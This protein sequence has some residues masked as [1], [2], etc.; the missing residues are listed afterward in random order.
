MLVGRSEELDRIGS[1]LERARA[2][3]A[4]ALVLRGEP[5]IGK[6]ALLDHARTSAMGCCVLRAV[7]VQSE[8]ELACAGLHQLLRPLLPRVDDLPPPQAAALRATFAVDASVATERFTVYLAT[9]G[10]IAAAAESAPVLCV[11]DDA[12]WL[13]TMSA[14]ALAFVARRLDAEPVAMLFAT[15]TGER[16]FVADGLAVLELGPLAANASEALLASTSPELNHETAATLL[17]AAAGNPLALVEL[18][19]ALTDDEIGGTATV[20]EPVR[21]T[22]A[23]EAAFLARIQQLSPHARRALLVVSALAASDALPI[24]TDQDLAS[25]LGEAEAAGLVRSVGGGV[26]FRHPLMRAAAY[27]AATTAER[28]SAHALLASWLDPTVDADEYAWQL[29]EATPQPD[30]SVAHLLVETATRAGR[31][32]AL[33]AQARTLERAAALTPDS[34][35]RARRLLDAGAAA[36]RG[37]LEPLAARYIDEAS[38]LADDPLLR[39][40]I[41]HARWNVR[42]GGF[43]AL[44]RSY[45]AEAEAVA[46]LDPARAA[47][48]LSFAGDFAGDAASFVVAQGLWGRA[49]DLLGG[50][51][52]PGCISVAIG[53]AWKEMLELR[54]ERAVVLVHEALAADDLFDDAYDPGTLGYAIEVLIYAEDA[55]AVWRVDELL[56]RSRAAGQLSGVGWLLVAKSQLELRQGRVRAAYATGVEAMQICELLGGWRAVFGA[57]RLALVEACIGRD[58]ECRAHVARAVELAGPVNR[59][60]HAEAHRALGVLALARGEPHTAAAELQ[61][62]ADICAEV[63]HPGVFDLDAD[64]VEALARSGEREAVRHRLAWAE[65]RATAA[66]TRRG[67]AAAARCRLLVAGDGDDLD[68]A[69]E[70]AAVL[71]GADA[72]FELARTGLVLGERLRRAGR[73]VDAREHLGRSLATFE[74]LGAEPWADHARRELRASGATLRRRSTTDTET[75][76][77]QELQV[78]LA[79]AEGR[80]NRDVGAALFISPKTVEL[81]LTR[82]YRKL[83]IHSRT[84]LARLYAAHPSALLEPSTSTP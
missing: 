50:R 16:P 6:T 42:P 66:G 29:A 33:G 30:A 53:F 2:G 1:L 51:L 45:V 48:M 36:F 74:E 40:D 77:P 58:A 32:G 67:R 19:R 7:G 44:H 75:L 12:H 71:H 55:S 3:H 54:R 70:R 72:P 38:S 79:V 83:G 81:H 65:E 82:V 69:Y 47:R 4:G 14:E 13:D 80:T 31:R 27:H 5:G 62:A 9:L 20:E 23:I 46:G 57:L 84:E 63:T 22:A 60:A 26:A 78:A 10:L 61:R 11:V 35:L 17:R 49:W 18:P 15:R 24:P 59:S 56:E 68:A 37:G 43:D 64:L 8:A 73:R 21:V 41:V 76:T 34:Q 39:A 25:G 52:T 28:R